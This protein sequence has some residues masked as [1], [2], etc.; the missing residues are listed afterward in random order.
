MLV[1]FQIQ[2]TVISIP[3][4]G[5]AQVFEGIWYVNYS[6]NSSSEDLLCHLIVVKI[7]LN[8]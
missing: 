8:F 3:V 6:V 7:P 5:R 4:F 1:L 2:L